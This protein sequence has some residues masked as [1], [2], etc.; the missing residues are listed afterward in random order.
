MFMFSGH[1]KV[2]FAVCLAILGQR[3]RGFLSHAL[4]RHSATRLDCAGSNVNV[5]AKTEIS[6]PHGLFNKNNNIKM[7]VAKY[8]D[9]QNRIADN[10]VKE[11]KEEVPV[12]DTLNT[13]LYL[14]LCTLLFASVSNQWSR[15]VIYYLCDF[16]SAANSFQHF[17]I[18]LNFN[19]EQ[20]A[21]VASFIFSIAFII[22]S[23]I[24][25]S[26]SDT[27]NRRVILSLSALTSGLST[28]LQA[29]ITNFI[30]L[31]P[32]R[33]VLG[34]SQGFTNPAAYTL[35]ADLFPTQLIGRINGI[36]SGGIY[37]GGGLASFSIL[38]DEMYG[39]RNTMVFIGLVCL[40]SSLLS[41]VFISDPRVSRSNN[42]NNSK[43]D[44]KTNT[45]LIETVQKSNVTTSI[46]TSFD[47]WLLNVKEVMKVNEVKVILLA[48]A[49]R[50]CAGFI[51]GLWKAP[52]IFSKF[53]SDE[54]YFAGINAFIVGGC[55]LASSLFGGLISDYISN[56]NLASSS[57]QP[58]GL[59]SKSSPRRARARVWVAAFGSMLATPF[60]IGF[61][62]SD[63]AN[64][65][66]L[67][68]FFEY[69]FG[70]CWFGPTLASLF[71]AVPAEKRGTAQGLISVFTAC[72]NIAPIIVG[73]LTSGRLAN[74]ELSEV[75]MWSVSSLYVVSA[76]LFAVA[77][78]MQDQ[79]ISVNSS[80]N[81]V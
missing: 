54:S 55:G 49:L 32:L 70:E 59:Q 23:F 1:F 29:F 42:D 74:F 48:S 35:I 26:V 43:N 30:S 45:I 15:Q 62:L 61:V 34:F 6:F 24:G 79:M 64:T 69:L 46:Q 52:F 9:I 75:L 2:I 17:N 18:G 14:V 53:P 20:Y 3:S 11:V 80:E 33:S 4:V 41:S 63:T 27:G 8:D 7:N 67:F 31:V 25:G 73:A 36:Y 10:I 78:L 28:I 50:F 40:L 77:A 56:P 38:I 58:N 81:S 57:I 68:L 71:T 19:R 21:L 39:W 72:G 66:L 22:S 16:S 37:L 5:T 65:A 12:E 51:I 47:V 13:K 44:I 76:L 60:W